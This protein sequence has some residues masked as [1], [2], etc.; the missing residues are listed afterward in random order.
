MTFLASVVRVLIASPSDVSEQRDAAEAVM[1]RWN[2]EHAEANGIL[3]MPV[4]WEQAA[5]AESGDRPQSIVNRQIVDDSDVLV[6]IF[7]TRLGTHTG[8]ATSGSVEELERFQAAGKP[9]ALFFSDQPVVPDSL[10]AAQWSALK[11]FKVQ[12]Q[13]RGLIAR[14]SD[15]ADFAQKLAPALTRIVRERF[16]VPDAVATTLSPSPKAHV[17][18]SM[19]R[20][21]SD[22]VVLL[23]NDGSGEAQQVR[24]RTEASEGHSAWQILHGDEPI[25][26]LAAGQTMQLHPRLTLASAPRVDCFVTWTNLDGSEGSSR[27]T[28]TM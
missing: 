5:T 2:A 27:N 9:V 13:S 12:Q 23:V 25:N 8:V 3:L 15:S 18:A 26:Y 24:L 7:W 17:T 4:R 11:E 22:R 19:H 28:L 21:G 10:D 20:L 16:G 6:G 14:F 1:L